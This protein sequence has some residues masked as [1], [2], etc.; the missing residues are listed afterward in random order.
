MKWLMM[1]S[2]ALLMGCSENV[3][4][5]TYYTELDPSWLTPCVITPPP[6]KS[7]YLDAKPDERAILMTIAYTQQVQ[8]VA[9]CNA[10]FSQMRE[11]NQ[12]MIDHNASEALKQGK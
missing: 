11:Y 1:I 9:T 7:I 4:T 8:S 2:I 12:R 5:Y 6:E 10:R 3:K